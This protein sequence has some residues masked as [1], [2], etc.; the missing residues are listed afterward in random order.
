MQSH[1]PRQWR[2]G[3]L[4]CSMTLFA[5]ST[6]Q[7]IF[8]GK[9][10]PRNQTRFPVNLAQICSAVPEIFDSQT[11]KTT[12]AGWFLRPDCA[13]RSE[14][15]QFGMPAEHRALFRVLN[16]PRSQISERAPF[17]IYEHAQ[18]RVFERTSSQH[19][20]VIP[21]QQQMGHPLCYGHAAAARWCLQHGWGCRVRTCVMAIGTDFKMCLLRKFCSNGVDFFTIHR[22]RS[23]RKMMD[24]NF[25]IRILWFLRIFLKFSKRR[26]AV[27]LR[28]IWT[29]MV[30]VNL[31]HSR[32]LATKFRQNRLTLKGRSAGRSAGQRHTDTQTGANFKMYLLSVLFES[33]RIFLQRTGDTDAKKWWTRILKFEF[34]D[35]LK[36]FFEIFKKELRGPSAADLDHYCRGQTR[37]E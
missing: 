3:P 21:R 24:Q 27:S 10:R 5:A 1:H 13:P 7:C 35:F 8:N 12:Q 15:P 31:D 14:C 17:W 9:D 11:N 25:E 26:R 2:N 37:S 6:S 16:V 34:C 23:S 33:S 29:I 19:A 28:L 18:C 32:V 36:E 4:C 22:R 30:A 20:Y